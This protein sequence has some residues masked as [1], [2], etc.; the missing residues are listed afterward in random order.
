[1]IGDFTLLRPW[2][3]LALL[4]LPLLWRALRAD[5]GLQRSWARVV[6]AHLLPHLLS[7][8]ESAQR[9]PLRL[10]VAAWLV[11][12]LALAGPAWE[13]L[14]APLYRNQAARVIALELSPSML[15]GDL[16]PNRLTRARFAVNDL[17]TRLGDGQ[18]ALLGYAGDAF[19][20]AP[21]T[22]DSAT[23][24][25]LLAELEPGVM[26]VAGNATAAAIR[27]GAELIHQ[28]GAG[29]GEVIL[30]LD[31]ASTDAAA[32]AREVARN[33]VRVSV[34]AVGTAAGAPVSLPQGDFWKDSNGNIVVPRLDA[35]PLRE[36]AQAGGGSFLQL[37]QAGTVDFSVLAGLAASAGES[38]APGAQSAELRDRGPWL[39]LLLIPL[40]LAGF[41]RGWL[42]VFLLGLGLGGAP[43]AQALGWQDLWQRPDQQ[44]WQSLQSGDAAR[45]AEL[46]RDGDLRAAAQFRAGEA[47]AAAAG[48]AKGASADAAYNRGN[49]LAQQQRYEEAIAAWNEALQ[50][51]PGHADAAA[52]KQAVEDWLRRNPSQQSDSKNSTEKQQ[53]NSPQNGQQSG[54]GQQNQDGSDAAQQNQ[55]ASA[56]EQGQDQQSQSGQQGEA[57]QSGQPDA[58]SRAQD[59]SDSAGE[60][61]QNQ[62]QASRQGQHK[63]GEQNDDK[64]SAQ[65]DAGKAD[66]KQQQAFQQAMEQA[67]QQKAQ[68][69]EAPALKPGENDEKGNKAAA[70]PAETTAEREQR[71]SV[72]QWL[73][74]VPDDPGGLLRRKFQL[75]YE[76]R[77]RAQRGNQ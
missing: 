52:N 28:S 73:Q 71:Q 34:L 62:D 44:A 37:D 21:M 3:L 35:A 18:V 63:P 39:A 50:R 75:E 31:A 70:A 19:V 22:D 5:G 29:G 42:V 54:S 58:G 9:W 17:L 47:E 25:N 40:A 27:R 15:A 30:V 1:M 66:A 7:G 67:L 10:A 32:A 76:R 6:D 60:S 51:D 48:W 12:T 53:Q 59:Q 33:G 41:R 77:Q 43:P 74:R 65:Q 69:G 46:A 57:A 13:R 24:R 55:D 61:Q 14:P 49:A 26:P 68:Q 16:K 38:A 8:A 4:A 56:G 45:A 72:E 11:A 36:L 2:W 20:V 64:A 23:V